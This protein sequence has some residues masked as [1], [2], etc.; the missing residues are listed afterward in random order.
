MMTRTSVSFGFL[1]CLLGCLAQSR[2]DNID[3]TLRKSNAGLI[4]EGFLV[5]EF[6]TWNGVLNVISYDRIGLGR[7]SSQPKDYISKLMDG[8]RGSFE[9]FPGSFLLFDG[10]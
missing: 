9:D 4:R 5:K 1:L 3:T 8:V 7:S 6:A 10:S 2:Y